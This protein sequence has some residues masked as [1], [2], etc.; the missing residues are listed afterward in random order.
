LTNYLTNIFNKIYS[1]KNDD[2][3]SKIVLVFNANIITFI[4]NFFISIIVNRAIGVENKGILA[5]LIFYPNIITSFFQFGTRQ[6]IVYLFGKNENRQQEL[7]ENIVS[8]FMLSSIICI[9]VAFILLYFTIAIEL[10]INL[11]LLTIIQIPQNIFI[12]LVGGVLLGKKDITNFNK[13]RLLPSIVNLII[14][15]GLFGFNNLSLSFYMFSIFISNLFLMVH[16]FFVLKMQFNIVLSIDIEIVKKMFRYGSVFAVAMLINQLNYRSDLFFLE[17]FSTLK[18]IGLY[19]TAV[20]LAEL[21]FQIPTIIGTVI[22][23]YSS[24]SKEPLEFSKKVRKILKIGVIISSIFSIILYF[25]IPKVLE[26][27]YGSQ[28]VE[29]TPMYRMLLIGINMMIIYKILGFD[30]AGKGKPGY[31]IIS[32]LIGL[33]INIICNFFL[34]SKYG[35]YGAAI[36]SSVSY[37]F[38]ALSY[39]KIYTYELKKLEVR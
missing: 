34:V 12:Y 19:S 38:M 39:I 31:A 29:S 30:L 7:F 37:T 3:F 35:G 1:I 23:T 16:L 36:S 18:E 4:V 32:G 9:S 17:K 8:I 6:A 14:I 15:S 33:S 5:V 13:I 10:T 22:F 2:L 20:N 25:L 24:N 26:L 11:I 21:L 28:F 27:L